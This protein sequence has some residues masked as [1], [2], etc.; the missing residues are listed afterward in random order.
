MNPY[1]VI[2][3]VPPAIADDYGH[4]IYV[5]SKIVAEDMRAAAKAAR[6]EAYYFYLELAQEDP[7]FSATPRDATDFPCTAIF[8][9]HHVPISMGE[10]T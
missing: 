7:E 8:C 6:W 1:T 4:D 9:G 3:M 5:A 2:L 10:V